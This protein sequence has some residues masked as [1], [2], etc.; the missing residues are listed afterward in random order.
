MTTLIFL[1]LIVLMLICSFIY[2]Y[3]LSSLKRVKKVGKALQELDLKDTDFETKIEEDFNKF[4]KMK[5]REQWSK[6]GLFEER[7]ICKNCGGPAEESLTFNTAFTTGR[8][9]RC[10]KCRI[11]ASRMTGKGKKFIGDID[12][13]EFKQPIGHKTLEYFELK[14]GRQLE[15]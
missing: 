12:N 15:K 11:E 3:W 4:F 10:K 6:I 9:F 1:F 2:G 7:I 5:D 14:K 13:F 8:K